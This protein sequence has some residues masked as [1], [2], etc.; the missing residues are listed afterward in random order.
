MQLR[1]NLWL[2]RLIILALGSARQF[3]PW[4]L[5]QVL[6]KM[7]QAFGVFQARAQYHFVLVN[8]FAQQPLQDRLK[9]LPKVGASRISV[10]R[11]LRRK[12]VR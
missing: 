6:T 5:R 10:S 3:Q 11:P 4:T 2:H 8:A 1:P 9:G 12:A 7:E